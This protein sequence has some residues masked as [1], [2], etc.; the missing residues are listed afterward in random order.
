MKQHPNLVIIAVVLLALAGC[1]RKEDTTAPPEM[2]RDTAPAE[3][4]RTS[5]NAPDLYFICWKNL[6]FM[7]MG[8]QGGMVQVLNAN[9]LP[10]ECGK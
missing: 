2:T 7:T 4:I 1:G 6:A 3:E 9:G 5:G 10:M 8:S